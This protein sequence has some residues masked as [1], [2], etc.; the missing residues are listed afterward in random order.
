MAGITDSQWSNCS[1]HLNSFNPVMALGSSC[2]Y[3]HLIDENS[4]LQRIS[5]PYLSSC[6]VVLWSASHQLPKSLSLGETFNVL[7]K[8][9]F[10]KGQCEEFR[11]HFLN[12]VHLPHPALCLL[13]GPRDQ[14][15]HL[16]ASH[17]PPQASGLRASKPSRGM[18]PP[19]VDAVAVPFRLL[20]ICLRWDTVIIKTVY[21]HMK[22]CE[23]V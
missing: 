11:A 6:S 8:S 15:P 14:L 16:W 5:R 3:P 17:F 2:Y 20:L 22:K 23:I 13:L 19:L 9:K 12:L 4:G 18:V 21:L 1:Y 10:S 7:W